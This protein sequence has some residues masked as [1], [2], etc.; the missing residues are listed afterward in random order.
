VVGDGRSTINELVAQVNQDPRRSDGHGTVLSRIRLDGIALGV[1]AEQGQ[2]PES[3][4]GSGQRV[5]IRRNANLS[6]GGTAT[7]V[8]D[9]VSPRVASQAVDAARAVGLDVAGIDVLAA[10]IS[11]P[12]E[13]Q[14][15]AVVEV[16]AGP[17]LRMHLE[18]SGGKPQPVGEVIVD[19]LFPGGQTGR[20]PIVA[21]TGATGKTTTT[22]LLAHLL[23]RPG[24]VVGMACS[25]GLY[26]AGRCIDRRDGT[27]PDGA[28][29]L[30]LNPRVSVAVLETA[31]GGILREGLG[32]DRADVAVVTNLGKGEQFG[33]RRVEA[34][35][36][37]AGARRA[38][39]QAVAR[40]GTAVLN[41]A[42]P[43]VASMAS[44]C[45]GSVLL[46][47]G[48][49]SRP[50]LVAQRQRGGR[51]ASVCGGRVV[52]GEG[53]Q[54]VAL[55]PLDGLRLAPGRR[56]ADQVEGILAAAAAAWSLGMRPDEIGLRLE[57]FTGRARHLPGRLEVQHSREVSVLASPPDET[58]YEELRAGDRYDLKARK[59]LE[60]P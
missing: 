9:L 38:L 43:L 8:T 31:P 48:E 32:L 46:F 59:Q 44:C 33:R 53:R 58:D 15:G 3:V 50:A 52:L 45:P 34:V 54:E 21:I 17:G 41:A 10:D 13:E 14:G 7:D 1:L 22:W 47:S 6:T 36:E 12:L 51:W 25:D 16:N 42:D 19:L 20:I 57:S 49:A 23:T 29:A 11:R 27:G 56:V 60:A 18:P 37:L 28:R 4:P 35:E 5:L 30:L 26:V 2:T 24:E 40:T 55:A 39:V